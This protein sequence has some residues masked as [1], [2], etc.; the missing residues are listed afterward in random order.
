MW[1]VIPAAG[2]GQ[3]MG[4]HCPKQ[5]LKLDSGQTI[6]EMTIHAVLQA[7]SID[8]VVIALS[9]QDTDF[10]QLKIQSS[11]PILTCIGGQSRADSVYQGLLFL[12]DKIKH[13]DFICVH[14][15]A[16]PLVDPCDIDRLNNRAIN[17]NEALGVILVAEVADTIKQVNNKKIIK[18]V[19]RSNLYRALTPQ[20]MK[21]DVLFNA[22]AHCKKKNIQVTDEASALE[23]CDHL[24]EIVVGSPKNIKVTYADDLSIV[25]A[26]INE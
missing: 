4:T 10:K 12:K 11:K 2:I 20:T 21:C 23:A 22:L 7:E 17:L 14:D 9:A 6:L 24:V 25:N 15:A 1:C 16:R 5:Y 18:T 26:L 19:D 3:R 8:G 13:N